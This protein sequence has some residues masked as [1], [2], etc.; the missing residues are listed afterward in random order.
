MIDFLSEN[1]QGGV[2]FVEIVDHKGVDWNLFPKIVQA[3]IV[4]PIPLKSGYTW[5]RIHF[6]YR[7]ASYSEPKTAENGY[8]FKLE[9]KIPKD[10]ATIVDWFK[11]RTK[12]RYLMRVTNLNKDRIIV[13]SEDSPVK[14]FDTDRISG[15][16]STNLNHYTVLFQAML[17]ERSIFQ[18]ANASNAL[19]DFT[20]LDFFAGDFNAQ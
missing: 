17:R 6:S 4:T 7:S 10:R 11:V 20:A 13:G 19:Y 18:A 1:N 5:E 8:I 15:N 9:A 2:L 14:I 12:K 16:I 3:N